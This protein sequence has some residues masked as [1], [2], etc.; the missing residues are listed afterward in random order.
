MGFSDDAHFVEMLESTY[1]ILENEEL[2]KTEIATI[3]ANLFKLRAGILQKIPP[4]MKLEDGIGG[5][6]RT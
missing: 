6:F 2:S 5:I 3:K 1:M 4:N